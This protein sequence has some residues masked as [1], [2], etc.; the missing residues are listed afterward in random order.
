VSR[1]QMAL[2]LSRLVDAAGLPARPPASAFTD[3]QDLDEATRRG[4][5][6][7]PA[8]G[9]SSGKGDGRF[10][11]HEQ[12]TRGQMASFLDSAHLALG[13]SRSCRCIGTSVTPLVCTG[14]WI[15][16][17]AGGG[18]AAGV[19]PGMFAPE[20]SVTRAQMAGFLARLL[21]VEVDDGRLPWAYASPEQPRPWVYTSAGLRCTL[22]GTSGN[23]VLT[24]TDGE[25]VLCGRGGNDV[26]EG[27]EGDDVLEGGD[28]DDRLRAGAGSD[29]AH[30]GPGH[31]DLG[32]EDGDDLLYGENGDDLLDGGPGTDLIDGGDGNDLCPPSDTDERLSCWWDETPATALTADVWPSA[33]DVTD[34][35]AE[36]VLRMHL[37]DDTGVER[38]QVGT[39]LDNYDRHQ[40]P[41]F[42]QP[43]LVSGTPTDGVWESRGIA[44]RYIEPG[45]YDLQLYI[46]DVV[47][48]SSSVEFADRVE[49]I[50]A[51]PDR[52]PP[53]VLT[54]SARPEVGEFPLDVRSGP[55]SVVVEARITDDL[56]GVA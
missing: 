46:H 23:D 25:D 12:V 48:R 55:A 53:V 26:L 10:A 33:V 28:G 5:V 41:F 44:R 30:G 17:I 22:V 1:R 52:T 20:R 16:R 49:V 7:V 31:D 47:G 19:S 6:T 13:A 2:F 37:Q 4:I 18:I 43:M 24:G 29:S 39:F 32:G 40:G 54:A 56:S 27:A 38:V 3:V 14:R 15:E 35:D 8:H 11:P 34:A 36:L 9:I 50:D 42:T 21:D 51:Q 45:L